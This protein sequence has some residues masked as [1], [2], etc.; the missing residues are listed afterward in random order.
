MKII[1]FG[2]NSIEDFEENEY[3]IPKEGKLQKALKN[4]DQET[5]GQFSMPLP[6]L[7]KIAD[8]QYLV[9]THLDD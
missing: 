5:F 8:R 7:V 1:T 4:L 2:Q 3:L 9:V 6:K